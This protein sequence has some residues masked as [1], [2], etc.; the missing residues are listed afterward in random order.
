LHDH[1][2]NNNFFISFKR[3][4]ALCLTRRG[5]F[6]ANHNIIIVRVSITFVSLTSITVIALSEA[7][8]LSSAT[9]SNQFHREGQRTKA[10]P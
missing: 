3:A 10:V 2:A 1:N 4:V 9:W 5:N 6:G 8:S 7:K